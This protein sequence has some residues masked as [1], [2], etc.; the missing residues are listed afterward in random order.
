MY[1]IFFR[2]RE[3]VESEKYVLT[4]PKEYACPKDVVQTVYLDYRLM[5]PRFGSGKEL[6]GGRH[7]VTLHLIIIY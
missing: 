2:A 3:R 6:S 5:I 1:V 7:S 4:C